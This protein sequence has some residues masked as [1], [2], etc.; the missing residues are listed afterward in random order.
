[1]LHEIRKYLQN[2]SKKE[3][4]TNRSKQYKTYIHTHTYVYTNSS[5]SM[6]KC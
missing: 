3:I 1:M 5:I 4:L 2:K 6:L